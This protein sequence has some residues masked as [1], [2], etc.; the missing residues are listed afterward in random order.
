MTVSLLATLDEE[1]KG[2]MDVEQ[3]TARLRRLKNEGIQD[4]EDHHE[5]M[6]LWDRI[7]VW[8]FARTIT[9]IYM[10]TLLY[11]LLRIQ[12]NMIAR[13]THFDSL[14]LQPSESWKHV[15]NILYCACS[16]GNPFLKR[17]LFLFLANKGKAFD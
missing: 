16:H 9:A 5:K 15:R 10:E 6:M 13:Y 3:S 14:P 8:S 17:C 4:E 7:K 1:L 12:F 11:L 2:L